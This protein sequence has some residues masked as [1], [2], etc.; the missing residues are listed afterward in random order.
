M[1]WNSMAQPPS[2]VRFCWV[3]S[4]QPSSWE[5]KTLHNWNGYISQVLAAFRTVLGLASQVVVGKFILES[6]SCFL[7]SE[8]IED[9][10]DP[11][12]CRCSSPTLISLQGF[13]QLVK[14]RGLLECNGL[15]VKPCFAS[16]N[17]LVDENLL[18]PKV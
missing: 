16:C 9:R 15:H 13:S 14:P 5:K 8:G 17:T 18:T 3:I 6:K 11:H 7:S 1:S 4:T 10:T 12:H 2:A